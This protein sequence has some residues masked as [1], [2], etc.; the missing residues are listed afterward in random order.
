MNWDTYPAAAAPATMP[1]NYVPMAAAAAAYNVSYYPTADTLVSPGP[2]AHYLPH[3]TNGGVGGGGGGGGVALT[4]ISQSPHCLPIMSCQPLMGL[5]QHQQH[6]MYSQSRQ[7]PS[8]PPAPSYSSRRPYFNS[9][10]SVT[11]LVIGRGRGRGASGGWWQNREAQREVTRIPSRFQK[12]RYVKAYS[13]LYSCSDEAAHMHVLSSSRLPSQQIAKAKSK[14]RF[15]LP[16]H[17]PCASSSDRPAD[18]HRLT[19]LASRDFLSGLNAQKLSEKLST[20]VRR[21]DVSDLAE[22][23][24]THATGAI[25]P[26]SDRY[27]VIHA[28]STDAGAIAST[29]GS[30]DAEKCSDADATADALCDLVEELLRRVPYLTIIMSTLPPR[31]DT[32]SC[33][34]TGM[35]LPNS[36]RRVMNVQVSTR[37]YDRDG[38][39]MINND[40]VLEWYEEEEKRDKLFHP[41]GVTLTKEGEEVL[42]RLWVERLRHIVTPVALSSTTSGTVA[43]WTI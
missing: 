33:E 41:D 16:S 1:Q 34:A 28:G 11:D 23:H 25:D 15:S 14:V 32:S 6:Q 29:T 17:L 39:V 37:L 38:V 22:L 40:E 2:A 8:T 5:A 20:P 21:I 18:C 19:M 42:E 36:V 9:N 27:I 31:F 13:L 35:S 43:A 26:A 7:M 10:H 12:H 3:Q 4:Q 24:S 30:G